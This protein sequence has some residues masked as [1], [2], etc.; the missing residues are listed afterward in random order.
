M[1]LHVCFVL[2]RLETAVEVERRKQEKLE[3]ERT[4]AVRLSEQ[5]T[6]QLQ[7]LVIQ[8][9]QQCLESIRTSEAAAAKANARADAAEASLEKVK[10]MM[11]ETTKNEGSPT[12]QEASSTVPTATASQGHLMVQNLQVDGEH[13]NDI[14]KEKPQLKISIPTPVIQPI[15]ENFE[16][17][18]PSRSRSPPNSAPRSPA[19]KSPTSP[20]RGILTPGVVD[21]HILAEPPPGSPAR[22]MF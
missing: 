19:P 10:K 14:P 4:A 22:P 1:D 11:A 13:V 5:R 17:L 21:R 9:Q 2:W 8:T 7:E 3:Q 12:L 6:S 16:E 20:D 15:L 18:R